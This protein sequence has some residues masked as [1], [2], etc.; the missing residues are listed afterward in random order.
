M[1]PRLVTATALT[2]SLTAAPLIA[3][4]SVSPDA[5]PPVL[6]GP[7]G[8]PPAPQ[9]GP[10]D[11]TEKGP[12]LGVSASSAPASLRHQVQ[13]PA[14]VGLVVDFISTK[15][16][17]DDAGLKQ[18]DILHKLN[19]QL[20]INPQQLAVLVRTFKPGDEV[21]LAIIR[22]GKPQTL[23]LRLAEKELRP[24]ELLQFGG[25]PNDP[26]MERMMAE[27]RARIA[28][29]RARMQPGAPLVPAR[30]A[31]WG[32]WG[33]RAHSCMRMRCRRASMTARC[34]S[35]TAALTA[36]SIWSQGRRAAP[37]KKR[38]RSSTARS[39]RLSSLTLFPSHCGRSLIGF[40][41]RSP[42]AAAAR[43]RGRSRRSIMSR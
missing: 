12:Y 22:D 33:R 18:F 42:W 3:G 32:W 23:T 39:I 14:G 40:E 16:P 34:R 8:P 36:A 29:M 11:R 25:M 37:T 20:L 6:I 5:P 13:L 9:A 7:G 27:Q 38:R 24:L 2:L 19:D 26:E 10:G 4:S 30:R 28:Q 21:M 31:R 17:A 35:G 43:R 41:A 1:S 15:S